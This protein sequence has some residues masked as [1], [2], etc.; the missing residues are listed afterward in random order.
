MDSLKAKIIRGKK[1]LKDS[2]FQNR[3]KITQL[4]MKLN[5]KFDKQSNE[6]DRAKNSFRSSIE[7]VLKDIDNLKLNINSVN[8]DL[9]D[10][11]IE[12][13]K[14]NKKV[15]KSLNKIDEVSEKINTIS[16]E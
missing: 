9:T 11:S 8:K 5:L 6:I 2:T 1:A 14:V 10:V 13:R 15:D 3:E 12:I 4:E 16:A 7:Q